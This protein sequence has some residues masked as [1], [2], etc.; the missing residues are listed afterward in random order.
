MHFCFFQFTCVSTILFIVW[1][2]TR[3]IGFPLALIWDYDYVCPCYAYGYAYHMGV[4]L[5]EYHVCPSTASEMGKL[6]DVLM[7]SRIWQTLT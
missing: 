1:Q 2:H 5:C 3:V 6:M 7:V 4:R